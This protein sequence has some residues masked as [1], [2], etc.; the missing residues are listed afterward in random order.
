MAEIYE[1]DPSADLQVL[2]TFTFEEEIEKSEN[3]RFYTPGI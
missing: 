2:E 3:M 1:F